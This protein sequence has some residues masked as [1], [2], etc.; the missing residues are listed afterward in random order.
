MPSSFEH[1]VHVLVIPQRGEDLA[2][3]AERRPPVVIL[4]AGLGQRQRQLLR[5]LKR[6]RHACR[7]PDGAARGLTGSRIE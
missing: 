3:D 6:D 5:L 7:L 4:L 2:R 1:H